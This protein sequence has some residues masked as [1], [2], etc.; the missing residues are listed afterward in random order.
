M[1]RFTATTLTVVAPRSG[2]LV[3]G[4]SVTE[5]SAFEREIADY[6]ATQSH[7]HEA[8]SAS[9]KK[10]QGRYMVA[11][12][13]GGIALLVG[14]F[15]DATDGQKLIIAL[16]LIFFVVSLY[17]SFNAL[18]AIWVEEAEN[19]N[20]WK[21]WDY[22]ARKIVFE[23]AQ[24]TGAASRLIELPPTP[25]VRHRQFGR[26][27]GWAAGL[28]IQGAVWSIFFLGSHFDWMPLFSDNL[29][30][31]PAVASEASPADDEA[32]PDHESSAP[33]QSPSIPPSP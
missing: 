33:P 18:R 29:A 16:A 9:A 11:G 5:P 1:L 13:A 31:P 3:R 6:A 17:C 30:E 21:K 26:W 25:R 2:K 8:E 7:K 19:A 4:K 27:N 14:Q 10:E 20:A 22:A 15:D 12:A 24:E 32:S 23:H 28:L